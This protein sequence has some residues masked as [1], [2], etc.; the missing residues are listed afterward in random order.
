MP[1]VDRFNYREHERRFRAACE[2]M[3]GK[4]I[5]VDVTRVGYYEKVLEE[6]ADY[7][8]RGAIDDLIALRG[9]PSLISVL[10]ESTEFV[11]IHSGLSRAA[12]LHMVPKLK[13]FVGGAAM[14]QDETVAANQPRNVGFEL[15]IAAFAASVGVNV[16]LEPPADLSFVGTTQRYFVECKRP[17]AE[18]KL[19]NRIRKGLKQLGR[20]YSAAECP[21]EA[22]GILAI[23]VS[24]VVNRGSLMLNVN[25][26]NVDAE[27]DRIFEI[28]IR[29]YSRYWLTIAD[30]RTVAVLLEL[31]TACQL[32][33]LSLLVAL[34]HHVFVVLCDRDSVDRKQ[35][36]EIVTKF[37]A[38]TQPNKSEQKKG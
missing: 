26:A 30:R 13:Q 3:R 25:T 17:F 34:R 16:N 35:L 22:R 18:K 24:R 5:A 1:L 4:G 6:L 37:A 32:T 27:M 9:A 20:R 15:L 38:P 36:E 10:T 23:S 2:W 29:R 8:D 21:D 31:R 12:D 11:D 7:H 33:D 28:L 19:A 14:L